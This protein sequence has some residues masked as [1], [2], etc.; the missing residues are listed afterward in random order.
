[1]P[2]MMAAGDELVIAD[3]I[4]EGLTHPGPYQDPPIPNGTPSEI[5]G[6]WA[7]SIQ[8]S[9]GVGEQRFTLEQVRELSQGHAERRSLQ[10]TS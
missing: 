6:K 4:A 8:Y 3:A 7:V 2:Y 5:H 10:G 9:R 1:M